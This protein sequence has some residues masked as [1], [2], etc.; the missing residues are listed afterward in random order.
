MG[1]I[2]KRPNGFYTAKVRRIGYPSQSRTFPTKADAK[3]WLAETEAAMSRDCFVDS[4]TARNTLVRDALAR[5]ATTVSPMHRGSSE[6]VVRLKAMQREPMASYSLATIK[7]A[8]IAEWRDKRLS[9]VSGS[10]VNRELNLLHTVFEVARKDWGIAMSCNPVADVRRP[11]SNPGR[12]RRLS[13]PEQ[14]VLLYACR[15]ARVWWLA[16]IVELAIHTGMRQSEVRTLMWQNINMG[17]RVVT[18]PAAATKTLTT[19]T[20]PLDKRCTTVIESMRDPRLG[21]LQG[22]V[23]PGVTRNALKLAF[24]RARLRAGLEDFH[25][26]DTRHEATSRLFELGLSDTEVAT[27]TGHK[28]RAMLARYTHL[29]AKDLVKKLDGPTESSE[30]ELKKLL[31]ELRR[32]LGTVSERS[33]EPQED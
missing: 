12:E 16:P 3:R 25:F 15:Q 8:I 11:R 2:Q 23:F 29:R 31:E 1:T 13:V 32:M 10:T 17:E 27:I 21:L 20:V 18:L 28:T 24:K 33:D 19:R 14:S 9:K 5:Y 4:T 22:P 7:T 30:S 6:E 26:H